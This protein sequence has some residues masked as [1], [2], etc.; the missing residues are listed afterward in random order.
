MTAKPTY[1]MRIQEI[2]DYMDNRIKALEDEMDAIPSDESER[3]REAINL[4]V[5][6]REAL[7]RGLLTPG[8]AFAR[9]D[10]EE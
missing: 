9:P 5:S 2:L 10:A 4:L 8:K 3:Y 6:N 7:R 1:E